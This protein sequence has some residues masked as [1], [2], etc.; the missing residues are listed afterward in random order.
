M[1]GLHAAHPATMEALVVITVVSDT[2]GRDGAR[3]DGDTATAVDRAD[4]VIH[5]GDFITM[6]ALTEFADRATELSGVHGNVDTDAVRGQLPET[7]TIT[8]D[9]A[10]IAVVHTRDGGD[11]AL[12][13]FGR[14]READLVIHGH[15]HRP[16]YRW[17]GELGLLNPGSHAQPR[18]NRPGYA[19]LTVHASRIEGE[20]RQPNGRPIGGFECPIG[21]G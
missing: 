1:F 19:E 18:G 14:E 7:R 11:T 5:A 9:G 8:H 15:S 12:A 6:A 10:R 3:L 16:E 4:L 20:L 13:M 21:D 2:H 17:T